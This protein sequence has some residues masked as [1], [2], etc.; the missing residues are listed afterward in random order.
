MSLVK[1]SKPALQSEQRGNGTSGGEGEVVLTE[2]MFDCAV[3]SLVIEAS[4]AR[5]AK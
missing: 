4:Y 2:T 1:C 5:F 3:A